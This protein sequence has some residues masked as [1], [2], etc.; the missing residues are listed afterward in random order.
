MAGGRLG[1]EVLGYLQKGGGKDT[2]GK[3]PYTPSHSTSMELASL[4]APDHPPPA[5]E[6]CLMPGSWELSG[7]SGI[8]LHMSGRGQDRRP[9]KA[10]CMDMS[11]ERSRPLPGYLGGLEHG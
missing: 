5:L 9:Q 8:R 11:L 4:A 7:A 6:T 2:L 3:R 1:E 10:P